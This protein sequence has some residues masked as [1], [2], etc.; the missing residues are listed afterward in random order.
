MA[1]G[2][3]AGCTAD[4]GGDGETTVVTDDDATVVEEDDD[5]VEVRIVAPEDGAIVNSPFTVEFEAEGI[6]ISPADQGEGNHFHLIIDA[7]CATPGEV[8]P[9]DDEH[10]HFGDGQTETQLELARGQHELCLQL[11][12]GDHVA[13]DETDTIQVNVEE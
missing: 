13:S 8:I 11:A 12:D 10:L 6:D 4:D 7:G 3:L 5:D 9:A 1:G 2:L